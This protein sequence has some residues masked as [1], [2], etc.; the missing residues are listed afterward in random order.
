MGEPVGLGRLME[1]AQ[2]L[3]IPVFGLGG[4]DESNVKEAAATGASI[5]LISA[6]MA[7]GDPEDAALRLLAAMGKQEANHKERT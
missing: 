6:I 2:R 4:I 5:A 3:S 1:A 7:S